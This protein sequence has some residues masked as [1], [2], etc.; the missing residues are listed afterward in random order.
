MTQKNLASLFS[1]PGWLL[2]Q[3]TGKHIVYRLFWKGKSY[4]GYSVNLNVRLGWWRRK[5]K[6]ELVTF[7]VIS[8]WP[9]KTQA[10]AEEARII[11]R[12][13]LNV[14]GHNETPNGASG[15][16][17]NKNGRAKF[18]CPTSVRVAVSAANKQRKANY[19]TVVRQFAFGG[20]SCQ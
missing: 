3:Y 15:A 18:G 13:Q 16:Y 7:E 12:R 4:V 10:V 9:T 8:S 17:G 6:G 11:R 14:V 5:L 1:T 20:P 2:A 19:Q